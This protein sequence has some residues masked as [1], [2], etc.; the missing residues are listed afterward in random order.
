MTLL[1]EPMV[2]D[3]LVV[4][5]EVEVEE[6]EEEDEEQTYGRLFNIVLSRLS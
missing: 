1:M 5:K 2:V 3:M 6:E 4:H